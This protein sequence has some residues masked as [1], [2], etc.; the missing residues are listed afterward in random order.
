MKSANADLIEALE[1]AVKG[2]RSARRTAQYMA[3]RTS[4]QSQA[5]WISSA[6]A[7]DRKITRA[8]AAIAKATKEA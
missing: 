1:L 8:N 2:L 4:G 3:D 5:V 6:N 7:F